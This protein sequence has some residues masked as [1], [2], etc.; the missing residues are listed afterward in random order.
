[1]T[2]GSATLL[3]VIVAPPNPRLATGTTAQMSATGNYSDGST[4]DLSG[5]LV[6]TSSD[7]TIVSVDSAGIVTARLAGM[8]TITA[9]LGTVSDSTLVTGV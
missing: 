1:M 7:A 3:S 2:V 8:A 4:Q 9:T 5:L 6:W